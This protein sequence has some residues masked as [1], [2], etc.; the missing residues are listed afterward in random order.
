M[1]SELLST[2]EMR[3]SSKVARVLAFCLLCSTCAT[4][5]SVSQ[6][7]DSA[8]ENPKPDATFIAEELQHCPLWIDIPP[9]DTDRR[10]QIANIYLNIA[11]YPTEVIWAGVHIYVDSY[12]QLDHRYIEAGY[13]VF[14]LERVVFNVPARFRVG[15]R[16]P[17]ST[18][19]N[20]S[21]P[22]NT[23]TYID[24]LW[25]YSIGSAGQ[26]V[27]SG[28]GVGQLSGPPYNPIADFDQMVA[29]LPRRPLATPSGGKP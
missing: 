21:I 4:F 22:E 7:N 26:L 5:A 2:P 29:R 12:T 10:Q 8:P 13:K 17:Y 14:A 3:T 6:A 19:G 25:P 1:P 20:P 9:Q 27:L 23:T 15:E 16:F 18:L 24:F 11:R 28:F